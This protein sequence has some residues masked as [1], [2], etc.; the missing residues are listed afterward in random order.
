MYKNYEGEKVY[1]IASNIQYSSKAVRKFG[2]DLGFGITMG[3]FSAVIVINTTMK[4]AKEIKKLVTK[5]FTEEDLKKSNTK[6]EAE[7]AQEIEEFLK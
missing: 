1:M 2:K 6:T 7:E 4:C 5:K 3:V